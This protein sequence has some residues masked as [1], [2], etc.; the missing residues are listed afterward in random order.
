MQQGE[1]GVLSRHRILRTGVFKRV[2][3]RI[4]YGDFHLQTRFQKTIEFT[5]EY[6]S[7]CREMAVLAFFL[8]NTDKNASV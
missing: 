7:P 4:K 1:E 5:H 2:R 6:A 3:T 8:S